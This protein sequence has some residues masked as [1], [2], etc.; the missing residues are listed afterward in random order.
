MTT[1]RPPLPHRRRPPSQVYIGPQDSS[2]YSSYLSS[3]PDIPD[4]PEP[5][6]PGSS[7]GTS[8]SGLPSPPATNSTGSGST[9][10]PASI[11]VRGG[12]GLNML[13][14][15]NI[16]TFHAAFASASA[17]A[18]ANTGADADDDYD[19]D[20]D[21][22]GEDN[23]ARLDQQRRHSASENVLALQ[24]VKSLTQRNKM[25]RHSCVL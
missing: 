5:P 15:S 10:D 23:T 21:D 18:N 17:G 16:K 11:A 24:R 2:P 7:T 22:D 19:N 20:N 1:R 14:G 25:V 4:L 9:G 3:P 8:T 12:G 6:S 13:N